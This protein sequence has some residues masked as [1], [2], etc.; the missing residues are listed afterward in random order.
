MVQV[1]IDSAFIANASITTA[2]IAY[3]RSTGTDSQ[4]N[5]LWELD[6]NGSM[7]LRGSSSA[8]RVVLDSTGLKV[9]D[10]NGVLRVQIGIWG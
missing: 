10:A 8:G 3:L 2:K 9:Y 4:G 5:P 1:F 6:P 7:I